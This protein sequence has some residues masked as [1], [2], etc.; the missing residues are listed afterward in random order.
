MNV[1]RVM[2]IADERIAACDHVIYD[3]FR[4]FNSSP[5]GANWYLFS[6]KRWLMNNNYIMHARH[7]RANVGDC[8]W[9]DRRTHF[10][11]R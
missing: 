4:E 9:R 11:K 10:V 1:Q 5:E 6:I 8:A 2:E 3:D 7:P